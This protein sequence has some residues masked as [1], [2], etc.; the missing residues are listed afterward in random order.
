MNY[1]GWDES[2]D[3]AGDADLNSTR[4]NRLYVVRDILS[5]I[6]PHND[7]E[8]KL[9]QDISDAIAR[10]ALVLRGQEEIYA[11]CCGADIWEENPITQA[12]KQRKTEVSWPDIE[13][14]I[15]EL[16]RQDPTKLYWTRPHD[17]RKQTGLVAWIKSIFKHNN[18]DQ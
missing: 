8:Q 6:Q 10:Y 9:W 1:P 12:K 14:E 11:G 15:R 17:P 18:L 3:F 5:T 2:P 4:Q 13:D 16:H 7:E